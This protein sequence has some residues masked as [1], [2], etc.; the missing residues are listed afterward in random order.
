MDRS[1]LSVWG[2]FGALQVHSPLIL[3]VYEAGSFTITRRKW[4][5]IA[6]RS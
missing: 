3:T 6:W 2:A 5:I 4:E 1:D